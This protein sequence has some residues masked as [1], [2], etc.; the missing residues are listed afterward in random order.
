MRKLTKKENQIVT[1][2]FAV[3]GIIFVGS[4]LTMNKLE[5]PEPVVKKDL[6]VIQKRVAQTKTNEIKLK[7]ME[8]EINQPLSVDVKDYLENIDDLDDNFIKLLKLDTSMVKPNEAGTYTYT[9]TY[10]K[11]KYNGSFIIKAK[12]LPKVDIKIKENLKLKIGDPISTD[13]STYVEGTLNDEVKNNILLD[14]S[15]IDTSIVGTYDISITYDGKLYTGK[16]T[17]YEPQMAIKLPENGTSSDE[18]TPTEQEKKPT[19]E[20]AEEQT[21]TTTTE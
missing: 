19:E 4:G 21:E 6:E 2:V 20:K 15:N 3:W 14:L 12:E 11:K 13:I 1:I 5:A 10:K 16:I 7:D 17:V 8:L 18:K 9:I